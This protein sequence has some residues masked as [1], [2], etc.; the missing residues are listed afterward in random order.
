M[1]PPKSI[2]REEAIRL[3][4]HNGASILQWQDRVGS[5]ETGKYADFV[6]L[7][8]DILSCEVD[9]IRDARV[10]ATCV[11]GETRYDPAGILGPEHQHEG[12]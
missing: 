4:T 9:D 7:D 12:A 2:T 8:R 10:L 1:A 11:A 5:I 6:V 3:Y